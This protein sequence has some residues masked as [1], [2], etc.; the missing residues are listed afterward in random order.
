MPYIPVIIIAQMCVHQQ[1]FAVV[2]EA[3]IIFITAGK[4]FLYDSEVC[5]DLY[6]LYNDVLS[7]IL[8]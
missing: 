4:I 3:R 7:N 8:Y 5:C 1:T 2:K 6:I